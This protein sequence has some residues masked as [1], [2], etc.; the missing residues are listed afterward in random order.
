MTPSLEQSVKN[1]F[2]KCSLDLDWL[3]KEWPSTHFQ[4][5]SEKSDLTCVPQRS[6]GWPRPNSRKRSLHRDR[7]SELLLKAI[8]LKGGYCINRRAKPV[9]SPKA[10]LF[11]LA[12]AA[13]VKLDAADTFTLNQL[14]D[15][16]KML[17][18]CKV[19]FG[20]TPRF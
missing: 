1:Q 5:F 8:Y 12:D 7:P 19:N 15:G 11:G 14:I 2:A 13:G 4:R 16:L 17:S 9:A 10:Q 6:R 18:L 20:Q 3:F